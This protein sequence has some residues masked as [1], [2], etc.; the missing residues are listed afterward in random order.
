MTTYRT[1]KVTIRAGSQER[2]TLDLKAD[3]NAVNLTGYKEARAFIRKLDG[4]AVAIYSTLDDTPILSFDADRTIGRLNLD[5]TLTTFTNDDNYL[6]G[7]V[8]V[9]ASN[10]KEYAYEE[11]E[12]FG[13]IVKDQ[14]TSTTSTSS[15]STTSTSTTT[16]STS[17]STSTT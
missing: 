15:T 1:N 14:W 4:N 10:D 7:Y 11:D 16:T 3:G 9:T 17:S 8:I 6:V 12:E 5:P 13:I 2:I